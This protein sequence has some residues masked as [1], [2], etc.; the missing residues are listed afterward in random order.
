M[1]HRAGAFS[2]K[3]LMDFLPALEQDIE[4]TVRAARKARGEVSVV[5]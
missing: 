2:A 4:I 3:R 1:R 5:A